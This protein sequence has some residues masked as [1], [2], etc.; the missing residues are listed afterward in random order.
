MRDADFP[1]FV[2]LLDAVC[3]LLSRGGYTPN[4]AN[5]ALWF[6]ALGEYELGAVR[7][8]FDAH[9][10]DAQR[11]RFVPT[12]ADIIAQLEGSTKDDG[13]P[14]ADEAWAI[15]VRGRDESVSI[16]WTGEVAE[17][18]GIAR[19]VMDLGDEVGAR[20]AFRDAYN[21]LVA[22]ARR[23]GA[24][25]HWT[26]SFGHETRGR[27][28]ALRELARLTGDANLP[29]LEA[30]MRGVQPLLPLM[31]SMPEHVREKLQAL[32]A[33]LTTEREAPPSQDVIDRQR[34]ADLKAQTAAKFEQAMGGLPTPEKEAA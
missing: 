31:T 32:L 10:K 13:R 12:P 20:V 27:D 7:A 28:A 8:G 18:W 2:E 3:S 6:R 11:G 1:K 29:Q 30:P 5:S 21:R 22:D 9:V 26:V 14:G 24:R 23:A 34:T 4:A 15:A 19:P 25:P 17:A 16:V 33:W